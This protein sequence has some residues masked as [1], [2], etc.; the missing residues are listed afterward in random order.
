MGLARRREK[1]FITEKCWENWEKYFVTEQPWKTEKCFIRD[2]SSESREKIFTEL[3]CGKDQ[4]E[5]SLPHSDP[6]KTDRK[7]PTQRARRPDSDSSLESPGKTDVIFPSHVDPVKNKRYSSLP[8]NLGIYYRHSPSQTC[9][10]KTE[11][12]YLHVTINVC[13][14]ARVRAHTHTHTH[15]YIHTHT[16][17]HTHTHTHTHS[18]THTYTH[19]L[20]HT[21]THTHTHTHSHTLTHNKSRFSAEGTGAAQ[22][23]SCI[24][25]WTWG[26]TTQN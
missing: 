25:S 17:T 22:N 4:R 14:R 10:C 9:A 11:R 26:I 2:P 19:A 24:I 6:G 18:H 20:S 15:T 8:S 21:H 23:W 7:S 1:F 13:V 5:N 16:C 12:N 3:L